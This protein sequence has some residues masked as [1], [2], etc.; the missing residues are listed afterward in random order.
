MGGSTPAAR[1][2][3]FHLVVAGVA[4]LLAAAGLVFLPLVHAAESEIDRLLRSQRLVAVTE[5]AEASDVTSLNVAAHRLIGDR[6]A[7][8]KRED[9]RRAGSRA[10]ASV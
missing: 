2:A 5:D 9:E 1:P 6:R 10:A 4:C 8:R 3:A 7:A